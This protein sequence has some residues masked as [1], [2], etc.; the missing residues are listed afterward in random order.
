MNANERDMSERY[1]YEVV[2]RLPK[3]QREEISLEL[4]GLIQ[5]LFEEDPDMERVLTK[6]G[7]PVQFAKRYRDDSRYLIGPEYYD[8]YLW[9]LKIVLLCAAVPIFIT[10][11]VSGILEGGG[12]VPAIV[13]STV[14]A[15]VN[16]TICGVGVF[17][18]VTLVFA[19][20][21]R[22]KIKLDL[23]QPQ[24]WTPGSLRGRTAPERQTWAPSFLPPVPDKRALISRGDSIA[25]IVF[26]ALF[27]A[28]LVFAPGLIGAYYKEGES[29]LQIPVFN[30]SQ[31]ALLL[32]V[33]LLW[34]LVGFVDEVTRL[35]MGC[36][37]KAVMICNILSG[38]LQVLLAAVL[39]KVLPLWNPNFA[40]ELSRQ[41]PSVFQTSNPFLAQWGTG[42]FS[43]LLLLLIIAATL[44]EIGVTVY[45][46]LRY[47]ASGRM[48]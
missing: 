20:M 14:N 3:D 40:S 41:F 38:A 4:R 27:G 7:D 37:C 25:G 26:I 16:L 47:G 23:R 8:D 43:N 6:L 11:V 21:E 5:E 9:M 17:G 42:L 48:R 30:L 1:L 35:V 24:K 10:A 45:K 19:V 13:E 28:L 34:L 2:R 12:L 29:L 18:G 32:P 46:T 31:W 36:Y 22:Q 44:L 33:L 15:I 39:L